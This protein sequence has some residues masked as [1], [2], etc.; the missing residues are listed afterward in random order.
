MSR[1][2]VPD[3]ARLRLQVPAY[4]NLLLILIALS[5]CALVR[6][7]DYVMPAARFDSPNNR[8]LPPATSS[9][10]STAL[11]RWRQLGPSDKTRFPTPYHV[12]VNTPTP[13][14]FE[15]D[16][17]IGLAFSGGGTRGTVFTAMCVKELMAL[18]D[19]VVET[20]QGQR[21]ISWLD[22]IDYVSGVSTGA[23]PAAA[24]VLATSPQC[25]PDLAFRQWPECFNRDL[26]GP[27]LKHL[28]YRPDLIARD[29]VIDFNTRAPIG[30][31]IASVFFHGRP[32]RIG[33]GLTFGDLPSTPVLIIGATIINDPGVPFMQTRLPYRFAL[34]ERAVT[35]W[36][37]GI[38]SFETFHSDPMNYSLAEASYN[39]S[40]FPGNL[41]SGLIRVHN[42]PTWL[43]EGLHPA[44]VAR[45]QSARNQTGYRGVYEV[46]DGGLS[47]NRGA[48]IIHRIFDR[49]V[50]S[51]QAAQKPLLIGLDAGFLELRPPSHGGALLSK[52]WMNELLA[53]MRTSWQTGQDVYNELT[54]ATADNDTYHYARFRFTAFAP[55]LPGG[56][57]EN[58]TAT[59]ALLRQLCREEP[60]VQS[61]ERLLEILRSIGTTL[62]RLD[63]TQMAAIQVCARFAVATGKADLL[64]WAASLHPDSR[65]HFRTR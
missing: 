18:G 53:A 17:L 64:R 62:G 60:L 50:E 25:P 29:L 9:A 31:A 35:P 4:F 32:N 11:E 22:E 14:T 30:G 21:I 8:P 51:G 45:M 10:A 2:N 27:S 23:I 1:R 5:G 39:S 24:F 37:V 42:D 15:G 19:L 55:Y 59:A 38:Q 47:D 63:D 16:Y 49:L 61:P 46:K 43:I 7:A 54:N 36:G 44:S 3:A 12:Y 34:D 57:G 26:M 65:A 48:Y 13:G 28:G 56:A 40:S 52:G 6:Y 41:R 33:S 58:D 20:R